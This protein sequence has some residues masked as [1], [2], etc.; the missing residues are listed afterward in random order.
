[1]WGEL[2]IVE[3]VIHFLASV[4]LQTIIGGIIL[5]ISIFLANWLLK[6]LDPSLGVPRP[7][8]LKIE[9]ISLLTAVISIIATY[10][11]GTLAR[12]LAIEMEFSPLGVALTYLL[13]SLAVN[14]LVLIGMLASMLPTD[15]ARASVVT[16][17]C[18]AVSVPVCLII[19]LIV[20]WFARVAIK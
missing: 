11:I 12:E 14:I 18:V 8:L 2:G 10:V 1:M 15:F 13:V 6:I 7:S 16:A 5:Y 3:L 4:V 17:C 9:L 19:G 20:L